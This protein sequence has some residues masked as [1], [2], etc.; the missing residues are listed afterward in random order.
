MKSRSGGIIRKGVVSVLFLALPV[1]PALGASAA[2]TGTGGQ[3]ISIEK[4]IQ[5]HANKKGG[6][7]YACRMSDDCDHSRGH[8]RDRD[9]YR[10]I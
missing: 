5:R 3:E 9:R 4:L 7:I 1:V 6:K 10:P 2:R 8:Y